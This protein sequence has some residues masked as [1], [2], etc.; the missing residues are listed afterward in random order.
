MSTTKNQPSL[1]LYYTILQYCTVQYQQ[2]AAPFF[3]SFA[4]VLYCMSGSDL[5]HIKLGKAKE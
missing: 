4:T 1:V 5:Q 2:A 3:H